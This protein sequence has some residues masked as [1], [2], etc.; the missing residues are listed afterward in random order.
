MPTQNIFGSKPVSPK[1]C[2]PTY[3]DLLGYFMRQNIIGSQII[4]FMNPGSF[5][6][7]LVIFL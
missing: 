4:L 6:L 7:K 5:F 1:V 3:L 2:W